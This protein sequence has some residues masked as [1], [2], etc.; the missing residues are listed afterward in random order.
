MVR[1]WTGG[2]G[3]QLGMRCS[4]RGSQ[5]SK[6]GKAAAALKP[7]KANALDRALRMWFEKRPYWKLIDH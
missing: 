2:G 3:G 5:T 4:V 6:E 7:A 1:M